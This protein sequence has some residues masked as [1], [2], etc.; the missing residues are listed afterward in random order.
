MGGLW[1]LGAVW[2]G[3]E[4]GMARSGGRA[5]AAGGGLGRSVD[6]SVG[7]FCWRAAGGGL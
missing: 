1:R 4:G 7:G 6:N 3:L 5:R 2:R